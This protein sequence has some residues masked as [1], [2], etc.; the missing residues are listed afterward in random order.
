[1]G[2]SKAK[3]QILVLKNNRVATKDPMEKVSTGNFNKWI[4]NCI[5][6]ISELEA[7]T[8]VVL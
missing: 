5:A 8:G 4:S 7:A 2:S 3:T 6:K 1:M